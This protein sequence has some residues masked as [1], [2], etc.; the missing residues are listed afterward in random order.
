M[1]L[2]RPIILLGCL[3]SAL[4]TVAQWDMH[5]STQVTGVSGEHTPLWLNAN[6]Y[7]VSSVDGS[8]AIARVGVFR[9]LSCDSAR[10]WAWGAGADVVM[11]WGLTSSCLV[12]QAYGEL[13]WKHGLLTVGSK[14]QPMEF[15]DQELSSGAQTLGINAHP[16]PGVRLA[17]PDYWELPFTKGW[18][19]FKGHIFYGMQTDDNWQKDFTNRQS[20]YTERAKLHT[21]A[22]FLRIGK[23]GKPFSVE[24]GIEMAC[25]YGG[26]SYLYG[27]QSAAPVENTDGLKGMI[28]ALIPSGGE[29]TEPDEYRNTDGNHLGSWLLRAN[30]DAEKWGLSVYGDHFFEDHSSMFHLDYDGYGTGEAWNVK[31]DSRYFLYDFKDIMLGLELRLKSHP[32]LNRFVVEYLYTKYQGGPVYHDHTQQRPDHISGNDNFYNHYIFTGWQHWG[33]VIGNPLYRSPLY[34]NDGLIKVENNRFWAWHFGLSGNP[35]NLHY[36]VLCSLQ[37]GLGTYDSP[38]LY[39]ERSLSVLVEVGHRF[40]ATSRFA[41]WSV[42][43]AVGMDRGDLR[44]NSL[45]LQ[46]TLSRLF[47]FNSK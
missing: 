46:L 9:S 21:K 33:Q 32:F 1:R 15:R 22:G 27:D 40:S 47:S 25:Q 45:G 19:A 13:K 39:P 38:V 2:K 3:L 42:T 35:M 24:A 5:I 10:Q 36:R 11:G 31:Q 41:G 14:E 8:S 7:G 16:F 37:E 28:H 23:A 26:R 30:Y 12:Q 29:A 43:G 18:L 6:K 34:N 20:K 17:L 4:S 44:G